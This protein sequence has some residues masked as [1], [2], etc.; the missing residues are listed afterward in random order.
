MKSHVKVNTEYEKTIKR[1]P[2]KA[3]E[4]DDNACDGCGYF[5]DKQRNNGGAANENP[6]SEI[7]ASPKRSCTKR[8]RPDRRRNHRTDI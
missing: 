2:C 4:M 1:C 7:A 6:R 3:L 5:R 8:G